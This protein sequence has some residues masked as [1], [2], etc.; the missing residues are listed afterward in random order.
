MDGN[1]VWDPEDYWK[2]M[3]AHPMPWMPEYW[4]QIQEKQIQPPPSAWTLPPYTDTML[5]DHENIRNQYSATLRLFNQLQAKGP[6]NV[7]KS[8]VDD[9][10]SSANT[11]LGA[12]DQFLNTYP[13]TE[14]LWEDVKQIRDWAQGVLGWVNYYYNYFKYKEEMEKLSTPSLPGLPGFPKIPGI[15]W[16]KIALYGIIF[17]ILLIAVGVVIK[18]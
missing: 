5:K 1:V 11:L 13:S 8:D 3:K 7:T 14:K 6:D 10:K 17:L 2:W 16:G 18:R 15:D 12:C 9:L 4:E